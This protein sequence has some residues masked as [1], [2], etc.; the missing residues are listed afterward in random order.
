MK[1]IEVDKGVS[2]YNAI[3]TAK[4]V[5]SQEYGVVEIVFNG[6]LLTIDEDSVDHNIAEIYRLKCKCGEYI[7]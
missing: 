6:I 2:I 5:A 3:A 4:D 7:K 1:R